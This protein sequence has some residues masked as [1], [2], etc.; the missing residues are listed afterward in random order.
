MNEALLA[1]VPWVALGLLA[2]GV[3]VWRRV[4]P[5]QITATLESAIDPFI[6]D[7]ID[8]VVNHIIRVAI[9]AVDQRVKKYGAMSNADRLKLAKNYVKELAA[10]Y[11][12]DLSDLAVEALIEAELWLQHHVIGQ[13][14]TQAGDV[15][16]SE[17]APGPQ[18]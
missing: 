16:V 6:P 3:F 8:P 12:R 4:G 15:V 10:Y 7:Q 17:P 9:G 11:Q 18:A 1:L 14:V 5:A 2:G 13:A